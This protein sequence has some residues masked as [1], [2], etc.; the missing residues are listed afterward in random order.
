MKYSPIVDRENQ[1]EP[2]HMY[3]KVTR[4]YSAGWSHLDDD[5]YVG[6]LRVLKTTPYQYSE[7]GVSFTR[8][9]TV[10]VLTS[11]SRDDLEIGIHDTFSHGCRCEHDC[12]GHY[13][14][15]VDSIKHTKRKE[16][17]VAIVGV[18]NI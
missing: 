8:L 12:C 3:K 17:A 15:Y 13:Q 7:E 1:M 9:I 6:S 10:K 14:V 4:R 18:A 2:I 5:V 11:T 16:Y